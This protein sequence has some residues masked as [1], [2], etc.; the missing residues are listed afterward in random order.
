[1]SNVLRPA[2]K[3]A[4]TQRPSPPARPAGARAGGLRADSLPV[5]GPGQCQE[6]DFAHTL[7]QLMADLTQSCAACYDTGSTFIAYIFCDDED[8]YS[9]YSHQGGRATDCERTRR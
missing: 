5:D 6:S 7:I 2:R 8:E 3:R 1:M 9:C 4:G